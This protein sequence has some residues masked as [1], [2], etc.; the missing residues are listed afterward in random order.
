MNPFFGFNY[1]ILGINNKRNRRIIM[2]KRGAALLFVMIFIFMDVSGQASQNIPNNDVPKY[3]P[4]YK[5]DKYLQVN[6][7]EQKEGVLV[8]W[9]SEQDCNHKTFHVLKGIIDEKQEISWTI[10]T[11][12]D[13][14]SDKHYQ[15]LDRNRSFQKAYYRIRVSEDEDNIEYTNYFLF[16]NED[17]SMVRNSD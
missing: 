2:I 8:K 9:K 15:F 11:R 14:K 7:K 10:L 13:G 17:H 12:I 6:L 5:A 1:P 3:L 16:S 4:E